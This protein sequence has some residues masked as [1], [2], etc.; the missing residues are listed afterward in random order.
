MI[1][2]KDQVVGVTGGAGLIGSFVV[3]RLVD[4]GAKVIVIDDFSKGLK[5]NIS[6]NFDKIEVREGN[7]ED[8]GFSSKCFTG[9]EYIFH[10]ASRAYGVAYSE[11]HH[12]QILHHNELITNNLLEAVKVIKPKNVL[13]TSSSCVYDDNGPDKI[14]EFPIFEKNPEIVNQGYGWAKRFLEQK[15]IIYSQECGIPITIVRPF[16]IYGERYNWVGNYSQ[17]IPMLVKKVMDR[18]VPIVV[19]GT[20]K[21]RR[22][23]IHAYDCAEI[24]IQLLGNKPGLSPI[25]IGTDETITMTDLVNLICKQAGLTPKIQFDTS[26]PEGRFIKSSDPARLNSILP[27]YKFEVSLSDGILRMINW[28][29][30]TFKR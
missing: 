7:L 25:N 11:G 23:Y 12:I 9:C 21:Q 19:W 24:M 26:R 14:P 20:G 3:D 2:F 22:N 27:D 8:V 6:H 1:N 10:L 4:R 13:I 5:E 16:N 17:A 29:H 15:S 18:E 28:Y 30:K